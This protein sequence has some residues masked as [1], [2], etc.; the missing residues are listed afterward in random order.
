VDV[1]W[2]QLQSLVAVAEEGGF[3]AAARRLH[4]SQQS[5]SALVHRLEVN[6]GI[7]LFDR[8]TRR[9]VPT[10]ECNTLVP[11]VRSAL[12]VIDAALARARLAQSQER[13]LRLAFSPATTFGPLQELLEVLGEL[14]I[15]N[16]DVREVWADELPAALLTGR[17]DAAI[18]VELRSG[19]ELTLVPWRRQRVELLVAAEHPF[20]ARPAVAV[21]DLGA[22]T[23][24]LP[25]QST[26]VG[27]HE[28]LAAAWDESG[29][30][31][32]VQEAPR[33]AGPAPPGVEQGEAVTVWLSSMDDRYVPNGLTRVAL[34]E[35]EI[36]VTTY[37]ATAPG[38]SGV[39]ASSQLLREAIGRTSAL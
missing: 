36:T 7:S 37:F 21:A 17:F 25:E 16:A 35:P 30:R 9:V 10:P 5:V 20:A 13:P 32:T 38:C 15:G 29:V 12:G 31:P 28:R 24:V 3:T 4:M 33:V 26:N 6:L 34:V 18:G 22:A 19:P 11:V 23:I 8:S 27:L 2:R 1:E 39:P 14:G